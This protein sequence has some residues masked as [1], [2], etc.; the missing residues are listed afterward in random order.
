MLHLK[1]FV[2]VIVLFPVR[3]QIQNMI[4]VLT[5]V[6]WRPFNLQLH[7]L[8]ILF[9]LW[10]L[11][12]KIVFLSEPDCKISRSNSYAKWLKVE[13]FK[14][15]SIKIFGV[16]RF[17]P[18][19]TFPEKWRKDP[20]REQPFAFWEKFHHSACKLLGYNVILSRLETLSERSCVQLL[21]FFL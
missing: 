19:F 3:N 9:Q 8:I 6:I 20:P 13:G 18:G 10:L 11:V 1:R 17:R 16:G 12:S 5:S 15:L 4:T 7:H 21:I 14:I 2:L